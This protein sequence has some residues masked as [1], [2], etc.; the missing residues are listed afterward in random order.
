MIVKAQQK[1]KEFERVVLAGKFASELSDLLNSY[2]AA[3]DPD[4]AIDIWTTLVELQR[5]IS[6]I[7]E[8]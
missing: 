4:E 6:S 2:Y 5:E 3:V 1:S 8:T 7:I